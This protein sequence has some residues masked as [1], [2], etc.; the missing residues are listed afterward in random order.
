M[1]DYIYIVIGIIWIVFSIVKAKQKNRPREGM[2]DEEQLPRKKSSLEEL[3]EEIMPSS[4]K[5]EVVYESY[6][7]IVE[8]EAY[9]IPGY[10]AYSGMVENE[11]HNE[12]IISLEE[13][14]DPRHLLHNTVEDEKYHSWSPSPILK[15]MDFF[16]LRKA[17]LYS[18]ILERPYQ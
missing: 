5:E 17:V 9:S 18:A 16:D 10:E 1:E 6:D 8:E 7:D 3:F 14:D 11:T 2:E 15:D 12:K 4:L 13:M